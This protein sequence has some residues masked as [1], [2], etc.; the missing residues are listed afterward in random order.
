MILADFK[1]HP[2]RGS[3]FHFRI[4]IYD[5]KRNM[6]RAAAEDE[7]MTGE[8]Q[9]CFAG[10]RDR[11]NLCA[12]EV[13]LYESELIWGDAVHELTHAAV[14]YVREVRRGDLAEPN[15]GEYA[16]AAEEMLCRCMETMTVDLFVRLARFKN[17]VEGRALEGVI[18]PL[19][20]C[21]TIAA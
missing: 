5:T 20:T 14:H 4:R 11:R 8:A 1:L 17:G 21:G 19:D 15:K 2:L 3:K 13:Y 6:E 9:A 7:S 18:H 12:G 10:S 16:S